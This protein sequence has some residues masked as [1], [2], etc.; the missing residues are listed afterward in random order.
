MSAT[1]QVL[2]CRC[3]FLRE[4]SYNTTLVHGMVFVSISLF[5]VIVELN[6]SCGSRF[7]EYRSNNKEIDGQQIVHMFYE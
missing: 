5:V 7:L 6:S 1:G 2:D 3:S 4:I